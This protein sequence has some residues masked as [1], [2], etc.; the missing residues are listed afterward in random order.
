[1]SWTD[2]LKDRIKYF[3]FVTQCVTNWDDADSEDLSGL[4]VRVKC[5]V[6]DLI[7]LLSRTEG[8]TLEFKRDLSSPEGA[9][10]AI[11][12]SPIPPG[13]FSSWESKTVR[14]RS[15]A[16]QTYWPRKNASSI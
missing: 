11:L 10:K 9:L 14:K 3:Q 2:T 5:R 15:R 4:S 12:R 6:V 8:K 7:T 1:M 16:S 13:V